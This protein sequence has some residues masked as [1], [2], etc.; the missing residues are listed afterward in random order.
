[1]TKLTKNQRTML[2]GAIASFDATGISKPITVADAKRMPYIDE[3]SKS[4]ATYCKHMNT[5]LAWGVIKR[6]VD[7]PSYAFIVDMEATR[8]LLRDSK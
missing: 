5:M 4:Y 1:M 3:Y 8:A 7:C 2:E 6:D